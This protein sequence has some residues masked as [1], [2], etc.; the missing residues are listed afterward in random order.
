MAITQS[1]INSEFTL[2]GI[3]IRYMVKVIKERLNL[4]DESMAK[5]N[6]YYV[7]NVYS[8]NNETIMLRLH[9]SEKPEERLIISPSMG[10]W[11]TKYD[12]A[13]KEL[14]G[15]ATS[16]RSK[17]NRCRVIGIEQLDY[18]RIVIIHL[19]SNEFNFK[20]ICEFF[21]GG[22]LILTDGNNKI[23]ALL[24]PLRVRHRQIDVG[25]IYSPP[26]PRGLS[27]NEI[28]L[29]VFS[30]I[31][32]SDLSI[33]KWLGRNIALSKKYIEELIAQV[34]LNP[35]KKGY[36]LSDN[37]VELL[38]KKLIEMVNIVESGGYEPLIVYSNDE[39]ID[40]IPFPFKTYKSLKMKVAKSLFEAFDEVMSAKII[41]KKRE[42]AFEPIKIKLLELEKAL[43]NQKKVREEIINKANSLKDFANK[44][45]SIT[46][47]F[48][49]QS[50]DSIANEI[51]KLG[52]ESVESKKDSVLIKFQNEY[53]EVSKDCNLY[54][55]ASHIYDEAKKLE[56]KVLAIKA[57]ESKLQKE[58]DELM[59]KIQSSQIMKPK[60]LPTR[61]KAWFERY[62]WFITSDGL[63]AVGGRDATTNSIIIRKYMMENDL[64]FHADLQGSP[65]FLLKGYRDGMEN[66]I[67]E[68]AQ[69]TVSY[70][71]AWKG[72]FVVADAY[73][74]KPN[75]VKKAA[76]SGMYLPKGSFII[77]G[78][79]NFV[80]NVKVELAIGLK[81]EGDYLI[82]ISGPPSAIKKNSIAYV[83]II[84][85][86]SKSSDTAK[87]IKS[88]LINHLKPELFEEAKR[89]SLDDIIRALPGG[90]R[91]IHSA[92][93][94]L[95]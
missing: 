8:V 95:G 12:L 30:E 47:Q 87:L 64:V 65:F 74:V 49:N 2:S 29:E 6:P 57:A 9:H 60:K 41:A 53:F 94:E 4:I 58:K 43:Q 59:K 3:E 78:K 81:R 48:V 62:R 55:L 88:E 33:A 34:E 22:N 91:V 45:I 19:N 13:D 26:P 36:E 40:A 86:K 77:E 7:N 93:G 51:V 38:F 69:A 73:W 76:P 25:M 85:D 42:E 23:L 27:V 63:L 15:I 90:G 54:S 92:I 31:K 56:K 67:L 70:S 18:E 17:I 50:I 35:E 10:L 71:K 5:I 16:L 68:V 80:K 52:A 82:V 21:G 39:I 75:Q 61:E 66:S 72:G 83:V 24:K 14:K 89:I 46:N 11:L 20:L 1:K 84:P 28:N 32:K 79:K 44:L 37:E